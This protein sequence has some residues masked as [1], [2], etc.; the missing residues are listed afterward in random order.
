MPMVDLIEYSDNC[1]KTSRSLCN[2]YRPEPNA[3]LTNFE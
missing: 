3:T 2:Y 1:S